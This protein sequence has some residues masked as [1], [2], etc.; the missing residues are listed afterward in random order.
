MALS[1]LPLGSGFET[2]GTTLVLGG[3]VESW[4]E[5]EIV[6][7]GGVCHLVHF[8]SMEMAAGDHVTPP[9]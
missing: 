8:C 4:R 3:I 6:M 9:K 7:D 5:L 1:D 2:L